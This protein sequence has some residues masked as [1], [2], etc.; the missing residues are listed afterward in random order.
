MCTCK[1]NTSILFWNSVQTLTASSLYTC[2]AN[3]SFWSSLHLHNIFCVHVK[4]TPTV[5]EYMSS[6]HS[7]WMHVKQTSTVSD[8]M[9]SKHSQHSLC[10]THVTQTLATQSLYTCK[11][12]TFNAIFAR[13]K[14][15]TGDTTQPSYVCYARTAQSLY[16][17]T[18]R[19]YL[20]LLCT[21][22]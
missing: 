21:L 16:T 11:A 8:Y 13:T 4:Q 19:I 3:T 1:A 2:K 5:S 20:Q 7:L 22:M 10:R 9:Q 14:I 15:L 18:V 17:C 12:N 6:K